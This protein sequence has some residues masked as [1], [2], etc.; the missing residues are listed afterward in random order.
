MATNGVSSRSSSS[1]ASGIRSGSAPQER[2]DLGLV[3]EPDHE[4]AQDAGGRVEP[5]EDEQLDDPDG[6]LVGD[7][8]AL[9]L[10]SEHGVDDVALGGSWRR[11]SRK[12]LIQRYM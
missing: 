2:G 8:P 4:L 6:L 9:D 1:M 7:G 12:S 11:C 5:A 3:A 10:G